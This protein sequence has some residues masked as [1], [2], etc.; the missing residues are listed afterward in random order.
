MAF[1]SNHAARPTGEYRPDIDGLRAIAVMAV[2]FYHVFPD[3]S[4]GGYIGVD[5]FFVISGYLI[6]SIILN[7][8]ND[9][10]FSFWG[11]YQR[12][13]K[14]I[15][16]ALV[17]VLTVSAIIGWFVLFAHEYKVLGKH[18]YASSAFVLNFILWRE[19][20][21]F[22]IA[23]SLKP[24]LHLWSLSVEEQF[25][26]IWPFLL[27]F[28]DKRKKGVFFLVLII[29][30]LSFFVNVQGVNQHALASF[31][32]IPARFWEF[33]VGY[34]LACRLLVADQGNALQARPSFL[35][36]GRYIFT[37]D[38]LPIVKNIFAVLGVMLLAAGIFFLDKNKPY[39]GWWALLPTLGTFL[40]IATGPYSQINKLL[41]SRVLIFIGLISYPL[42]LWH[43]PLLAFAKIIF[44]DLTGPVKFGLIVLSFVLAWATY[45]FVEKPIRF[46]KLHQGLKIRLVVVSLIFLAILGVLISRN[47]IRPRIFY[48][49]QKITEA[50]HDWDYPDNGGFVDTK[51]VKTS[52]VEGD[53]TKGVLVIGDSHVKQYWSRFKYLNEMNKH[54]G[55]VT[56]APSNC[57]PLPNIKRISD[58]TTCYNL[59]DQAMSLAEDNNIKSV[60]FGAYWEAYI[61]GHFDYKEKDYVPDI[62]DYRDPDNTPL[63]FGGSGLAKIFLEFKQTVQVL[64]KSGKKVTIILSNPTSPIYEPGS[65]VLSRLDS[66]IEFGAE[67]FILKQDYVEFVSPITNMLRQVA[68]ETGAEIIDPVEYLCGTE[69]CLATLNGY[70]IYKDDNHLRSCYVREQAS[71]LDDLYVR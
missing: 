30:A 27:W 51:N 63:K 32:L 19:T 12:R 15:F 8:L 18:I 49:T 29:G 62:A 24:L 46:S 61:I 1:G 45:E 70:P 35:G 14:R 17:V 16:P 23:S 67:P 20:G 2:I 65:M 42:Y 41:G 66:K 69:K 28:S 36:Y 59:F 71:F 56:F 7:D 60:V 3:S 33:I 53:D 64:I 44:V 58:G 5:I 43:W 21:Y 50:N 31:Y 6:S 52:K 25:Y 68:R 4:P 34:V 38:K 37:V 13:I 10:R 22:E 9:G 57:P 40:L 39:P 26:M 47:E 55:S 48:A 54:L 11:F